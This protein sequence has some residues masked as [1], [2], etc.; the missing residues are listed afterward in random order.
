MRPA[1]NRALARAGEASEHA[2]SAGC[3]RRQP[4]SRWPRRSQKPPSAPASRIPSALSP[5]WVAQSSAAPMLPCSR[6]SWSAHMAWLASPRRGTTRSASARHHVAWARRAW[7]ASPAAA[8]CSSAYSRMVS[9]MDQ[10]GSPSGCS[11]SRRSPLST[12]DVRQSSVA[13]EATDSAAA[14]VHPPT[15]TASLRNTLRSSSARRSTLQPMAARRVLCRSGASRAPWTSRSSDELSLARSALG[16]EVL[17]GQRRAR[18]RAVGHRAGGTLRPRPTRRRLLPLPRPAQ[19][20]VGQ[21][22]R[23]RRTTLPRGSARSARRSAFRAAGRQGVPRAGRAPS[24]GAMA[25]DW[26]S[27]P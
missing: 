3:S 14:W 19:R 23:A 22:G 25:R 11:A 16:R 20:L 8:S 7:S 2:A 10:R 18:W 13:A 12:S 21:P 1:A 5:V 9:S 26:S 27:A 17:S 15:H 6:S 24:V 4:S